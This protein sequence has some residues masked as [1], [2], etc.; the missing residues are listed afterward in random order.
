MQPWQFHSNFLYHEN[1]DDFCFIDID[2]EMGMFQCEVTQNNERAS[3]TQATNVPWTLELLKPIDADNLMF[4]GSLY[5]PASNELNCASNITIDLCWVCGICGI[6]KYDIEIRQIRSGVDEIIS[7]DDIE[8]LESHLEE[9]L[10]GASLS[11]MMNEP[12]GLMFGEDV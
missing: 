7:K 3:F 1:F 5:G 4:Y 6:T 11:E 8:M 12:F 2:S 10:A 9:Q